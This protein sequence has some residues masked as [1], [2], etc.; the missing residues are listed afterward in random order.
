MKVSLHYP[1]YVTH[2]GVRRPLSPS[3]FLILMR[4]MC[5]PLCT[6]HDIRD[7][8][9]P[10]YTKRPLTYEKQVNVYLH[11]LRPIIADCW[12]I[13]TVGHRGYTLEGV[14]P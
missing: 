11:R 1:H 10:G 3:L 9:W 7:A 6:R 8:V 4:L 13:K 5:K 2:Q 14:D 12:R